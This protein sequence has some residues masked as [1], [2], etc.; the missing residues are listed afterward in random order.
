MWLVSEVFSCGETLWAQEGTAL[1]GAGVGILQGCGS[2]ITRYGKVYGGCTRL[3]VV[4]R[5][6]VEVEV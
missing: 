6:I 1:R 2:V 3:T 5:Y 4:C